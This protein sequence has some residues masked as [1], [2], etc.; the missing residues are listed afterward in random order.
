MNDYRFAR[1]EIRPTSFI[2]T[3]SW[4]VIS[5]WMKRGA[6]IIRISHWNT[7][8]EKQSD[9]NQQ[10]KTFFEDPNKI[11]KKYIFHISNY[12][13]FLKKKQVF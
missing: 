13:A 8:C 1:A 7:A 5:P 11:K 4:K 6:S 9:K 12:H 2:D 3:S 10:Q